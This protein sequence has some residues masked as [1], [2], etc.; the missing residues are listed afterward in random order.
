MNPKFSSLFAVSSENAF[1]QNDKV[2]LPSFTRIQGSVSK[3]TKKQDKCKW[4]TGS[5]FFKKRSLLNSMPEALKKVKN[6]QIRI[7]Y[8]FKAPNVLDA[9]F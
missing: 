6:V 1:T 8:N 2:S 9:A 5:F 7:P 3:V 4:T